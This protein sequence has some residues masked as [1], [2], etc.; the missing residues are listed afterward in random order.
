M[1][2]KYSHEIILKD[3]EGNMF[4]LGDFIKVVVSGITPRV[5]KG[6]L[7]KIYWNAFRGS[8][9]VDCSRDLESDIV[10]LL[11]WDIQSIE[12]I[13]RKQALEGSYEVRIEGK[14]AV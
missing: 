5:V 1:K 6:R 14:K 3:D 4:Y 13:T 9:D 8:L 2:S 12:K 11:L 7:K 10:Q